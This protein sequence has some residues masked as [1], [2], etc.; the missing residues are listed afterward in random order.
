MRARTRMVDSIL[1]MTSWD[2]SPLVYNKYVG[3]YV[4][5][6][7]NVYVSEYVSEYANEYALRHR[8]RIL[9]QC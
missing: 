2:N 6:C 4:N 9:L 5:E 7:A 3:G 8:D 1:T